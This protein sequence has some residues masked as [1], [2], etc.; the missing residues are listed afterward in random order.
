MLIALV[1]CDNEIKL[2]IIAS[3]TAAKTNKWLFYFLLHIEHHIR[4]ASPSANSIE[5]PKNQKSDATAVTLILFMEPQATIIPQSNPVFFLA[6]FNLSLYDFGI[7]P[8]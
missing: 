4:K 7:C 8:I 3:A 6:L 1:I 2:S 5:A